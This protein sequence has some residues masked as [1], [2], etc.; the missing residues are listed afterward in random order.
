MIFK[1]NFVNS[2]PIY[3]QLVEQ[4]ELYVI[5]GKIPPG[6]KL[7]SV[8]ELAEQARVNPN[9]MQR[10]LQELES[11]GLIYTERTNGKYVT[12]HLKKIHQK[13]HHFIK[14]KADNFLK[15]M[16][17]LGFTKRDIIKIIKSLE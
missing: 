15:N 14:Q 4:L 12:N 8:R 2:L 1:F 7:P 16:E 5:S 17:N 9:T 10:A 11:S 6:S 3:L 13:R